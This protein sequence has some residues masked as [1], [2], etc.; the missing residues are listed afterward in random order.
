MVI[1]ANIAGWE[2]NRVLIDSGSSVDI[3]FVNVFDQMKL[4]RSQLQPLDSPL[5]GFRGKRIDALEKISLPVFFGGQENA[6]TEYVTFD[7]VYL[8]YP[9]NAIF[10]RGFA[11]KFN[12]TIHMGYMCMK[13]LALHGT[14]TI[15]NSQKEARNIERAIYK[16]Q[17]NINSVE[18]AK[19]NLPEPP[20]M[21][22]G[23]IDLKDQEE[24]KLV[25]LEDVVLDR[26]VTIRGNL[27]KEEEAELI[28]TLAKNKD[29]FA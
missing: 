14:I 12:A 10:G 21:P 19:S 5:I 23:K 2:I 8:Y 17:R 29:I 11:N 15:H 3:I 4:S 26:K 1:K 22:K 27:S 7:V 28:E 16:S 20:D 13:M 24:T 25:P 9:Y 6:R 18:A